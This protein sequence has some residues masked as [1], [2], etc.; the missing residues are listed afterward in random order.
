MTIV[1]RY[2]LSLY[3]RLL[4]LCTGSF[5]A[6]YLLIDF[7]EKIGRFT[8]T[9]PASGDILLYFLLKV[10]EILVQT[11]PLAVLMATLLTLG[12]LARSSE[13]VALRSCGVSLV[14]ISLPLVGA[15]LLISIGSFV[16]GE[17]VVP[18]TSAR[19]AY[20]QEVLIKK[21]SPSTFFRQSNIWYRDEGTIL[22]AR[23][24]DPASRRLDGVTVWRL[25]NTMQPRERIE[26][27]SAVPATAGWLLRQV[28]VRTFTGGNVTATDRR[29]ELLLPIPLHPDDLKEVEK[30]A[31]TMGFFELRRLA[32]KLKA[33]GYDATRYLALMQSRLS[34]PFAS[35]VMAFL[36][37]PFSLRTGR[38]SGIAVGIGISLGI[39][40]SYFVIN[41]VLLSFGQGGV[42]PP[43][44]AAWAA[45]LIFIGLGVWLTLTV[46][47]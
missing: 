37:I 45:N 6:I 40:F 5:V 35:L 36:G 25:S 9:H 17:F 46:N 20:V 29:S 31:D 38:S 30:E 8:R 47:R 14:K 1:G 28:M 18:R 21:K 10:P 34:L 19:M 41:S 24:F 12:G 13:L 2:I 32:A 23:H 43:L 27:R 4:S 11:I 22:Q 26:A 39:G 42:L 44:I 16:A 33:G 3:W 15:A 7:I